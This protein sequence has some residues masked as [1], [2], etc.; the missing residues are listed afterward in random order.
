MFVEYP[1]VEKLFWGGRIWKDGYFMVSVG[2]DRNENTV[3]NYGKEQ[4][5]QDE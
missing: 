2:K 1:E 5:K 3:G 4:G